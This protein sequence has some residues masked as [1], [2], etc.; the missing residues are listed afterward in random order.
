MAGT[1]V[2]SSA[3]PSIQ[4]TFQVRIVTVGNVVQLVF[5]DPSFDGTATL[6]WPAT[7]L[8]GCLASGTESG[9]LTGSMTF[10]VT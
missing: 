4:S 5:T 2:W 1:M 8:A 6:A 10:V 9:R 3:P 7:D